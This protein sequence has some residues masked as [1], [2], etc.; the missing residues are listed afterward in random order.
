[1]RL[2]D[3]DAIITPLQNVLV[4]KCKE[5]ETPAYIA[6]DRFIEI[7]RSAPTIEAEPIV[8]CG[9][10]KNHKDFIDDSQ[11]CYCLLFYRNVNKNDYCSFGGGTK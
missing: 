5:K 3:A 4:V 10:C 6:F 8:R 9:I 7:L 2:I 11:H 1:M